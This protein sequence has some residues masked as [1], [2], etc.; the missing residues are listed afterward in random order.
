NSHVQESGAHRGNYITAWSHWL[1]IEPRIPGCLARPT[2]SS[3]RSGF[4]RRGALRVRNLVWHCADQG[5][6]TLRKDLRNCWKR[7]RQCRNRLIRFCEV[8]CAREITDGRTTPCGQVGHFGA[9]TCLEE[10]Q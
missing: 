6:C 10:S 4:L 2:W 9:K 3:R 8:K 7:G 5:G 1:R